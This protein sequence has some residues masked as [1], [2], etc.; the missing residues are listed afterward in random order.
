MDAMN[1]RRTL[2]ITACLAAVGTVATC[3][4]AQESIDSLVDRLIQFTDV[5]QRHHVQPPVRQQ[6]MLAAIR[7]IADA[8]GQPLSA[9]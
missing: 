8:V 1:W 6:M 7:T 5:A 3:A 4:S 9:E 2:V